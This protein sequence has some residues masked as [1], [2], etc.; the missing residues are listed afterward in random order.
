M[1]A[2]PPAADRAA[3]TFLTTF[4]DSAP[5]LVQAPGRVNVI[6]EHTDYNDGFVL[7]IALPFTTAIAARPRTDGRVIVESEGFGRTEFR[8]VDEPRA[9]SGWAR[10]LHG[11]AWALAEHLEAHGAGGS[12]GRVELPGWDGA[13]AT[14]IPAGASLSSS[15]AI[16]VAATLLFNHLAGSPADLSVA[17]LAR[18]GQRVENEVMGLPSGLLDQLASAGG[19]AGHATLIDCR[20][21][22][23]RAV[24]F[25]PSATIVVLDTGTRRELVESEYA[26]RQATCAAA[27]RALGLTSLRDAT[28]DDLDKLADAARH[29]PDLHLDPEVAVRRVRHVVTENARTLAAVEAMEAGELGELG[30]LMTASHVSLREDYE[31]SGPALDAV[32]EAALE[33]VGCYGARMTGGGFAGGAIALV[34]TDEVESFCLDVADRYVAPLDQPAVAPLRLYPTPPS[35]GARIVRP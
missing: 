23:T 25:P 2:N 35:A 6:G 18:I 21:L 34:A 19:Q 32:V 31:V 9:T 33:C 22:S 29:T 26:D 15:A 28:L 24:P 12:D 1:T 14:D 4:N 3:A 13:I 10:Y 16:E 11:V 30:R 17:D 27:A 7:P 5:V 20:D 8:L